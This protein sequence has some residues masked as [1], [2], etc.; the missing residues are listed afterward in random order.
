VGCGAFKG[1]AKGAL[2]I[3]SGRSILKSAPVARHFVCPV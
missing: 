2:K 3:T 1:N